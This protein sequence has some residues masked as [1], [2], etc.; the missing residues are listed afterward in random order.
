[1]NY[2]L[3]SLTT[4]FNSRVFRIPDYQ[5]GYAWGDSQILD[6]W[7]DLLNLVDTHDHYTGMLTLKKIDPN[8]DD[9]GW[10]KKDNWIIDDGYTAYYV[11]DGQQRL[12]TSIILIFALIS[13]CKKNKISHLG[14]NSIEEIEKKYISV[15]PRDSKYT[16]LY[17]FNYVKDDPSKN[18]LEYNIFESGESPSLDE[19]YYTLN[20][21]RAKLFFQ[22]RI[23]KLYE[24]NNNKVE[25]ISL[26]FRKL[27]TKFK[28]NIFYIK[29][30]LDVSVAFET[31]NNRGKKL[32]TLELL[33]NRLIY[34][35]NIFTEEDL[36]EKDKE[37][38]RNEI[39]RAWSEI[40]KQIGRNKY[41]PLRDEDFL[42]H[43]WN[44]YYQYYTKGGVNYSS[45]LLNR[46][47]TVNRYF[48]NDVISFEIFSNSSLESSE[49]LNIENEETVDEQ[50]EE[51]FEDNVKDRL[52]PDMIRNYVNSLMNSAKYFYFANNPSV[53]IN[54]VSVTPE[55]MVWLTRIKRLGHVNFMP[56][57][58]ALLSRKDTIAL[59]D[60][61]KVL[62]LIENLIF[63][64]FRSSGFL[65]TFRANAFYTAARK[66]YWTA[67]ATKCINF[68]EE[69]LA[70][71]KEV[72]AQ[73]FS[74]KIDRLFKSGGGFYWW[75]ELRYF[76]FEYEYHL[77]TTN[78]S[79]TFTLKD[80]YFY[81]RAKKNDAIS[82]EHILPQTIDEGYGYWLNEFRGY[83]K[84]EI[85]KMTNSLGNL[86]L[87]SQSVNSSFSNDPFDKKKKSNDRENRGY[88]NG[89][90]S[91]R[92][93]AKR[94]K[95]NPKAILD[96]GIELLEF[97]ES[98]WDVKFYERKNDE[99]YG[100]Y[101]DNRR[102]AMINLLGISFVDD[103]RDI[104]DEKEVIP[105]NEI[106][107]YTRE[108]ERIEISSITNNY[109]SNLYYY[110]IQKAL[111][112]K[113]LN[114]RAVK[115][116]RANYIGL[117]KQFDNG[118]Y[119]LFAQVWLSKGYLR[120]ELNEPSNGGIGE[121][122]DD[123]YNSNFNYV[124]NK[125]DRKTDLDLVINE[126]IESYNNVQKPTFIGF[127]KIVET[128]EE[129]LN[130]AIDRGEIE[131]EISAWDVQHRLGIKRSAPRIWV[132]L[133][134]VKTEKDV[135]VEKPPRVTLA[136]KI[137]FDLISRMKKGE[138]SNE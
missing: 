18:Y 4:I 88:E 41:M 13:F 85:Q 74:N 76:F 137:K 128:I 124:I 30:E 47:F 100:E 108:Y 51:W 138:I 71:M 101:L 70:E 121:I 40:Y 89:S 16:K 105:K 103:E 129:M 28:F 114:F 7:N 34:L 17:L 81:N 73:S 65:A 112:E 36:S 62:E 38:L 53:K 50:T 87:L 96:R 22:D 25:T 104:P 118:Y 115:P 39:N 106:E 69:Q 125:V 23:Q 131:T 14:N 117:R 77:S 127:Q 35:T 98:Y 64:G 32:S 119:S 95:W 66:L 126:L 90:L 11:I 57:I 26:L 134:Y 42:R 86:L 78:K 120:I 19:T 63:I 6:F 33:K 109:Y 12:T 15:T 58:M 84:D 1:M 60:R 24:K 75:S 10:N 132:A 44:M 54:D 80:D 102:K 55:E 130:E 61:I 8:L 48:G 82:I 56:M 43:H 136:Y 83:N 68:L 31:M 5:R 27:V 135:I 9:D 113:G 92:E 52:N 3:D 2:E 59:N 94:D 99:T 46:R 116:Q 67:D 21:L 110:K 97:F 111:K 133:D 122:R 37:T 79:P 49:E 107:I 45:D 91:E 72:F 93:V 123:N 29:N 20:L